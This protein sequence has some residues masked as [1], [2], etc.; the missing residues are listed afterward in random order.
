MLIEEPRQE[1]YA[2][3]QDIQCSGIFIS[4]PDPRK[5]RSAVINFVDTYVTCKT[6]KPSFIFHSYVA[7]TSSSPVQLYRFKIPRSTGW[8]L[9][10]CWLCFVGMLTLWAI[11][12]QADSHTLLVKLPELSWLNG[13]ELSF[14]LV[15]SFAAVL[16]KN[17][18]SYSGSTDYRRWVWKNCSQL[19]WWYDVSIPILCEDFNFQIKYFT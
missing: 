18:R 8:I 3:G 17:G 16:H 5:R 10:L 11:A 7:L 15:D 4:V 19:L 2:E 6:Y 13:E 14:F 12:A 1:I 9:P